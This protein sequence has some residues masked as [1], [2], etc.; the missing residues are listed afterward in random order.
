MAATI[1]DALQALDPTNDSQ[2]TTEDLPRLDVMKELLSRAVT[3]E[4]VSAAAPTF[5]RSNPVVG[6]AS[7][8]TEEGDSEDGTS[9][10]TED[11]TSEDID[12][13]GEAEE[14]LKSRLAEVRADINNLRRVEKAIMDRLDAIVVTREKKE[15][16]QT[17]TSVIQAYQ[18]ARRKEVEEKLA[19]D[20]KDK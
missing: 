13:G 2:W 8:T 14:S 15:G 20:T 3:R 19:A 12:E 16:P 17:Y 7:D 6:A 1:I 11:G 5:T 9:E 10:D 4:E 18:A